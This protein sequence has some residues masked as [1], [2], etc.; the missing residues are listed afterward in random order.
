M[1]FLYSL[2]GFDLASTLFT[3]LEVIRLENAINNV[4]ESITEVNNEEVEEDSS[5]KLR[6]FS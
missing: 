4:F 3:L 5:N 1:E 6:T 2:L